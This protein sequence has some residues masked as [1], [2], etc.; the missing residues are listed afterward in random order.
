MFNLFKSSEQDDH[1]RAK[2][3]W[4][5]IVE[6]PRENREARSMRVRVGLLSRA[7]LDKT[8]VA[9]AEQT[10]A[11]EVSVALAITQAKPRPEPP[12]ATEYQT[13]QSTSGPVVAYLP[14]EYAQ[15]A[16][17]LGALYQK[18]ELTAEQAISAMQTLADK[19]FLQDIKM[20]QPLQVL[21]FLR[22]E[23]G[24]TAHTLPPVEESDGD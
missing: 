16:F 3:V 13:V 11:Y 2:A 18:T 15:E 17:S 20:D 6:V 1:E 9:G 7:F 21:Q 23:V 19:I 5:K 10:E 14:E 24:F 12:V 8:F 4:D 22:E